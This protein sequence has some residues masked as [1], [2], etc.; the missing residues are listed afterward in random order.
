MAEYNGHKNYNHW[1]VY[2]WINADEPTYRL[3]VDLCRRYRRDEA[4]R[5]LLEILPTHTP[6]G[7][8]Y[9]KTA[10]RAALVGI[11]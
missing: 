1:A 5:R 2:Q 9:T 6:D 11:I 4:A 10:V 7:T 8:R 3:A